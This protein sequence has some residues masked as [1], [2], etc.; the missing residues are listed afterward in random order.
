VL[1]SAATTHLVTG[2]DAHYVAMVQELEAMGARVI[3]VFAGG[4]ISPSQ[5]MPTLTTKEQHYPK[6]KIP[7]P[8]SIQ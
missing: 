1:A 4:Q 2:D 3:P 5:S 7:I 6:S 8:S